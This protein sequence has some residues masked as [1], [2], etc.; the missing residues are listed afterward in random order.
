[1]PIC[2]VIVRKSFNPTLGPLKSSRD[3]FKTTQ[4]PK[5]SMRTSETPWDSLYMPLKL[6]KNSLRLHKNLFWKRWSHHQFHRSQPFA[7]PIFPANSGS[8][9]APHF[10]LCCISTTSFHGSSFE[11]AFHISIISIGVAFQAWNS[12]EMEMW[13]ETWIDVPQNNVFISWWHIFWSCISSTL[14]Y[15]TSTYKSCN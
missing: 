12:T 7:L 10:L 9:A 11:V 6:S 15:G 8:A 3:P 5:G 14:F 1:M 2:L 4:I 13:N